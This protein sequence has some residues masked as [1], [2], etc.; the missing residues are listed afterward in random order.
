MQLPSKMLLSALPSTASEADSVT[1]SRDSKSSELCFV[2]RL[3]ATFTL[4][5]A[6][7]SKIK[8]NQSRGNGSQNTFY[9]SYTVFMHLQPSDSVHG[10][11]SNHTLHSS[12]VLV[13]YWSTVTYELL[14][15]T[16]G[17]YGAAAAAIG[18]QQ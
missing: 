15:N 8:E 4:S 2:G 14:M 5:F 17:C 11:F 9:V 1:L 7:Q 6:E 16:L 13:S 3:L 10:S 12:T 18:N